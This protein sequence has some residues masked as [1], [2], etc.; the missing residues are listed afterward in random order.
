MGVGAGKT[1]KSTGRR[2][3]LMLSTAFPGS[4]LAGHSPTYSAAIVSE[5]NMM[6]V[7]QNNRPK[8]SAVTAQSLGVTSL[9]FP[10]TLGEIFSQ[11][12]LSKLKRR[13]KINTD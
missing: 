1:G 4:Q 10:E 8:C 7:R 9:D 12:P 2:S 3:N 11:S 13:R 6:K 5:A